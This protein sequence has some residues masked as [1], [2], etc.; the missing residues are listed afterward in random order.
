[1]NIEKLFKQVLDCAFKVHSELGPGLLEST[2][3]HCLKYELLEI[4]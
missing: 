1:M 4:G 3:E 2:Y